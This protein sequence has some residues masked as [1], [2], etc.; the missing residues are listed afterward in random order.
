M[1]PILFS[2]LPVDLTRWTLLL[3]VGEDQVELPA[4]ALLSAPMLGQ[5]IRLPM[6]SR[7]SYAYTASMETAVALHAVT[8][9]LRE[10][11]AQDGESILVR[12]ELQTEFG[13]TEA[14]HGVVAEAVETPPLLLLRCRLE[15]PG[16]GL[17]VCRNLGLL[18]MDAQLR[19]TWLPQVFGTM[20]LRAV[21]LF[22][23]KEARLAEELTEDG[24]TLLLDGAV[25]WPSSGRVQVRDEVLVYTASDDRRLGSVSN[26][27][28]RAVGGFHPRG[29]AVV[30]LPSGDLDWC[31]ADHPATVLEIRAG[32]TEGTPLDIGDVLQ[33]DLF[34]SPATLL[35]R[36]RLPLLVSHGNRAQ[37]VPS[38]RNPMPWVT[39]PASTAINPLHAFAAVEPAD[40]AILTAGF[41]IIESEYRRRPSR[42]E[43]RFDILSAVSFVFQMSDTPFW[44]ED[45]RIRV[46]ID[47]AGGTVVYTANRSGA[48]QPVPVNGVADVP[49]PKAD[50]PPTAFGRATFD[51]IETTNTWD[52]PE[53]LLDNDLDSV[54]TPTDLLPTELAFAFVAPRIESDLVI[55]QVFLRVR[56]SNPG[57]GALDA[58]LDIDIP[59]VYT[60]GASFSVAAGDPV[61]LT[62]AADLRDIA[63]AGAP[64]S[65]GARYLVTLPSGMLA[66]L[67]AWLDY[68][69]EVT[70]VEQGLRVID[71]FPLEA[72]ANL[73]L[74][75]NTVRIELPGWVQGEDGWAA[76]D[77]ASPPVVRFELLN[78]PDRPTWNAYIRSAGFE[79]RVYR[80]GAVRPTDHVWAL[81]RGRAAREDGTANP[82]DVVRELVTDLAGVS[83]DDLDGA[84]FA[85]ASE[86]MD[87][88]GIGYARLIAD[89]TLVQET[90]AEALGEGHLALFRTDG[91]WR[92]QS[93]VGGST[94]DVITWS[95]DDLMAGPEVSRTAA[96]PADNDLPMQWGWVVSGAGEAGAGL[97]ALARLRRRVVRALHP[98]WLA[99]PAGSRVDAPEAGIVLSVRL[100]EGAVEAEVVC[101]PHGGAGA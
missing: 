39:R 56:I 75:Y 58:S 46:T 86:A 45:T 60:D 33:E 77:P 94:G 95:P 89:G 44:G 92:L 99:L 59:G 7:P 48:L 22:M 37:V 18:T 1:T 62:F 11:F 85:L 81:V 29:A 90:L 70:A 74:T 98:R 42:D 4:S 101:L 72:E 67:G 25:D 84:S 16:R 12:L 79:F 76:F 6:P 26:P 14:F 9:L 96:P 88:C 71:T 82:A 52:H 63:G 40:G 43:D 21:P 65:E 23:V 50:D 51:R 73:R 47:G 38:P 20:P 3:Q 5:E 57:A 28:V 8:P 78:P 54:A 49:G 2:A 61:V 93:L 64:F 100:R 32:G 17:R 97:S 30:L 69:Y 10:M 68:E 80:A 83:G 35:R 27:L 87:R 41:D 53:R 19:S 55:R 36:D 66:V 24:T 13:V 34:E 91:G 15:L 31:L